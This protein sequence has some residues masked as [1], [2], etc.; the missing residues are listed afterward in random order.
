[1]KLVKEL[2]SWYGDTGALAE[3]PVSTVTDDSRKLERDCVF[4]CVAGSHFDGHSKAA[5]ALEAGAALVVTQRDLGLARQIVTD[6]TRKAYA[7]LCAAFFGNPAEELTLI[8]VTGTN[9]KTTTCFLLW[10]ILERA[11]Y[12][13]GLLGTV[14]T[15]TGA[16]EYGA[17]LTTPD[18]FELQRLFREMVN[19]G[20]THCVMEA[21]SQA[22][23]QQR[24]AGLRFAAAIFTNLT[25]DHLDYHGT[26]E[27]Y[28]AAKHKLF[29]Q[30]E[31]A[32][33]NLDDPAALSLAENTNCVRHTFST[34]TDASDYT[35][36]NIKVKPRG[37][38]FELVGHGLIGRVRCPLPGRFSVSNSLGAAVCALALGVELPV[39]L[40]AL[41]ETKGVPGRMEL[42]PTQMPYS[43]IIDYA[44]TPDALENVLNALKESAAGRILTVFG[45]GGDR[46]AAKRPLMGAIA[47]RLS[48]I[49]IVTSDNPR[50]EDPE[51][52]IADILRGI[53]EKAA[54]VLTEPDRKKAIALALEMAQAEDIV[55]LAGKG[56]ET[57]QILGSG[58]IPF[59]EREVVA[60]ILGKG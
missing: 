27:A 19:A 45:C 17:A 8:G 60:E 42:V 29:E 30:A 36:K 33:L 3:L 35:A 59:D 11:G 43:I 48:A 39:I 14:K 26:M 24:L 9:G 41:A 51:A 49:A 16:A 57:Y 5:E 47:A 50:S 10:E 25:Q 22:L 12:K 6:D 23:A 58:K 38:C 2:F 56:Q 37:V 44:H 46:D 53:P 52:I 54:H 7:L 21:S 31:H 20:C 13:C 15:L 40:K 4:V 1:M 55:L 28:R 34:Q 32:V 18:P